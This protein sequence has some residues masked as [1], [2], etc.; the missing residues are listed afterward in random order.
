MTIAR[1]AGRLR[2][3]LILVAQL[4]VSLGL[5]AWV[6]QHI[7]WRDVVLALARVH[8]LFLLWGGCLYYL[9]ILLSCCKWRSTLQA[10]GVAAPYHRLVR[11]YLIGAFASNF[12][13]SDVGG[14]VGRA[15][16]ASRYTGRVGAVTRSIVVERLSGFAILAL[17]AWIG[18]IVIMGQV[19]IALLL[20]LGGIAA[21]LLG[22]LLH[23]RLP[24]RMLKFVQTLAR[25]VAP[26]RRQPRAAG[27]LLLLSIA[28]H[29]L[30]GY[31]VWAMLYAVQ[32]NVPL[33]PVI[34]VAAIANVV[35]ALPITLSGWGVREAVV[36]SLLA[37]FGVSATPVL[38]GIVLG[39]TLVLL[40][41]LVGVV[42]L[43]F[44]RKHAL[45]LDL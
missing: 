20:L 23:R 9:G 25:T 22:W 17:F 19:L 8:P 43:M 18:L 32:V 16:Y 36:V 26:Y 12:L 1:P 7:A 28:F 37:P 35:S 21:L 14:D 30:S 11:W 27:K 6:I 45:A 33:A 24:A 39:R 40:S 31:S 38:A 42:P 5:L 44:E 29:L 41:S 34:L 10:E 3:Y 2:R 4:L 13:P 15:V